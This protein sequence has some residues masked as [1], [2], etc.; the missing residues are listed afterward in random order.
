[1]K[2]GGIV[3]EISDGQNVELELAAAKELYKALHELLGKP[4]D[5]WM[6]RVSWQ[7]YN[8]ASTLTPGGNQTLKADG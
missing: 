2:I 7:G 6:H 3:I 4:C 1:M 5:C 8:T